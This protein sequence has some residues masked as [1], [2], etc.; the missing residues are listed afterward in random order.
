MSIPSNIAEGYGRNY[1]PEYIRFLN[2]ARGSCYEIETQLYLCA[3]LGYLSE[4]QT[5]NAFSLLSEI[6]RLLIALIRKLEI[7]KA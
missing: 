7:T 3:D 5:A 1:R 2:V 6:E 4:Q